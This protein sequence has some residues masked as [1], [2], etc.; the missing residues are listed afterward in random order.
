MVVRTRGIFGKCHIK[1]S[2]DPLTKQIANAIMATSSTEHNEIEPI[3]P[4]FQI[5]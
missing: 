5:I 3:I 1:D 2:I 4:Y